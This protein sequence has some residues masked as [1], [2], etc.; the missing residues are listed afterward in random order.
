MSEGDLLY[1]VGFLGV[2]GAVGVE[3][4]LAELVDVVE[5]LDPVDGEGGGVEFTFAGVLGGA[6]LALGTAGH[7]RL[8]GVGAVSGE[9]VG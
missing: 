6:D 3:S 5:A 1:G 4:V 9:V 8:L 2:P 7:G